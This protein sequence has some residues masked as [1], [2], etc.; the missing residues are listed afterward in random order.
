MSTLA[1]MNGFAGTTF[2]AS[3]HSSAFSGNWKPAGMTPTIVKL[4]LLSVIDRPTRPVS[5]P[6][7]RC[8]RE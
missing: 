4:S 2:F 6:K 3:V 5:P 1:G 7:R 8:Q